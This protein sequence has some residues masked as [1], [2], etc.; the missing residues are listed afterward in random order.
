MFPEELESVYDATLYI[1]NEMTRL[2]STAEDSDR[3]QGA[4]MRARTGAHN[5]GV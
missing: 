2:L 4:L 5:S 1:M 3:V